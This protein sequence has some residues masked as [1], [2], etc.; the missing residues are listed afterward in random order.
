VWSS[1]ALEHLGSL[2]EGINFVV[3]SSRLLKSGGIGVHTT[4]FNVASN[5]STLTGGPNVIYRK[6]DIEE[7]DY[8]LRKQGMC[9]E[10]MDFRAGITPDD[11]QYDVPPYYVQG[12]QHIKLLLAD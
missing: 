4:E 3:N 7:L 11:R 10:E 2:E 1:C 5:N 9:L 12:R 8:I 6:R